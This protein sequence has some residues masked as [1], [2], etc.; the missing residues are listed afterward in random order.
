MEP[1]KQNIF[2]NL[3]KIQTFPHE[4]KKGDLTY[5]SSMPLS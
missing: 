4:E 2:E 3:S 5:L 1:S